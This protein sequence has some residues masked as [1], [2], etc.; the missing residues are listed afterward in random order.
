MFWLKVIHCMTISIYIPEA[1]VVKWTAE[2]DQIV[3]VVILTFMV[4]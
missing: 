4:Y 2:K 1:C 3:K